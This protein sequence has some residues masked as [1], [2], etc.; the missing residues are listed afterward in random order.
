MGD[1]RKEWRKVK[2]DKDVAEVL[3]TCKKDKGFGPHLDSLEKDVGKLRD[4]LLEVI[5]QVRKLIPVVDAV[6]AK[7]TEAIQM[8]EA[9]LVEI[10][11]NHKA[12]DRR[13]DEA[14]KL[15]R[16]HKAIRGFLVTP[17][18]SMEDLDGWRGVLL[19]ALKQIE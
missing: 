14:L 15:L 13:S 10:E 17:G 19:A 2:A 4:E 6:K 8:G 12:L 7:F 3:K 16:V 5:F 1:F 11:K 9:V 18:Q